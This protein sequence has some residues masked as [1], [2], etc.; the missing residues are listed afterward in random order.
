[1]Q[2]V[3]ETGRLHGHTRDAYYINTGNVR[4]LHAETGSHIRAQTLRKGEG[5]YGRPAPGEDAEESRQ[6]M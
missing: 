4:W 6:V 5:A 1:M 3:T 2:T